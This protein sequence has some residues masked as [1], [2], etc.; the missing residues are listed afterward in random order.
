M[1]FVTISDSAITYYDYE[2]DKGKIIETDNKEV[3]VTSENI[4]VNLSGRFLTSFGRDVLLFSPKN[5]NPVFKS[6]D[7]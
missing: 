1:S 5:L 2:D 6:I 4:N 3:T 7:K